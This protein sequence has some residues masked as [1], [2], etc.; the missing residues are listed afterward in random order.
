MPAERSRIKFVGGVVRG[1][2]YRVRERSML[3]YRCM[4]E[5]CYYT[6]AGAS[7]IGLACILSDI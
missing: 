1:G 2:A 7:R 4:S 5:P 3:L 6:G